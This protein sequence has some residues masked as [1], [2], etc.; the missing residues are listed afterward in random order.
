M[1]AFHRWYCR[2]GHWRRFVQDEVVP[3]VL[4]DVEL[5]PD[6][7]EL[8]PGPGLTTE[9]LAKTV[10]HLVAVEIDARSADRLEQRFRGTNVEVIEG[11]ATHLTLP[12]G[13]F[14]GAL[15]FTMLHHVPSIE[16]QDRL[17]SEVHRILNHGGTFAGSDST[18]SLAFR[19]AHLFDTMVL[20]DPDGF[21]T[22]LE[23]AGFEDVVVTNTADA[24]KFKARKP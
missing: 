19:A 6:V 18:S 21:V 23:R 10:P 8:G 24:F 4:R 22:R 3:W 12:N 20:V 5:G 17:L 16:L 14:S 2:S 15:C 11:D 7:L 13:S 1:N 9:V